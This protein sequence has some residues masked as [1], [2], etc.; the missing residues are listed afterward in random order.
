MNK[1]DTDWVKTVFL[2]PPSLKDNKADADRLIDA[3]KFQLH[4]N[5]AL[6]PSVRAWQKR[7]D[8]V[9][10]SCSYLMQN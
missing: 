5:P 7:M 8:H 6:F 2:P 1:M 4:T 3:L 10:I 9:R